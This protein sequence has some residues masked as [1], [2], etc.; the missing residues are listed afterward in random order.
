MN[1]VKTGSSSGDLIKWVG[2]DLSTHANTLIAYTKTLL[3]YANSACPDFIDDINKI[4]IANEKFLK[5]INK[6]LLNN[7]V[8]NSEIDF[9]A[10]ISSNR[11][12]LRNSINP[13]IGYCEMLL[14]DIEKK[15][16][17][18]AYE[19]LEQIIT[20]A[21]RLQN[22]IE[23]LSL[24]Q[25]EQNAI[26]KKNVVRQLYEAL[27][28]RFP[29][30]MLPENIHEASSNLPPQSGSLLVVD[31]QESNRDLLSCRFKRQGFEVNVAKNGR[32]ALQMIRSQH[33]D[34]VLLDIMMPDMDGYQ[35]L[36]TLKN[37]EKL[38]HIPVIMISGLDE[39]YSVV[40]CIKMGAEDYLQ[41]PFHQV[42]LNAKI[43]ATLERKRLHEKSEKLLLNILPQEI[44]EQLKDY[45]PENRDDI[46]KFSKHF[47]EV[48]V[49]FSDLVGFTKLST[50]I[51]AQELV[52]E[53]NQI[54]S[55]FDQLTEKYGLEKIKTI[56]DAYMLAGGLP[57]PRPDHA[58][59]VANLAI[60]ML[61]VIEHLNK[62]NRDKNH[63]DF[64]IRI[65]IHTGPVV[66]GVI[67]KRKFNYD[68]W[69]ET[70]NIASRMESHGIPS[71][72]QVSEATYKLIKDEFIFERRGPI[73]VKGKG[74]MVTYLLKSRR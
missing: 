49:L 54:F 73:E 34:L 46:R 23:E 60:E 40:H 21:R 39:I 41:K 10:L 24:P 8:D 57:S 1:T 59:A 31:D 7:T 71:E 66:A 65:G 27:L 47:E 70:V 61:E 35:V 36:A 25:S 50:G 33:F 5:L 43:S 30:H 15:T 13:I 4:L 18:K 67:G 22:L 9:K 16:H 26:V 2:H 14:E 58:Q 44:A 48:T 63:D 17:P 20:T 3:E 62:Q 68:L 74:K 45:D 6:C 38:R 11:H 29:P 55:A 56:G 37:D 53:L 51:S 52:D 12:D 19:V 42:I 64:K 72:I 32:Q 69:G 28:L